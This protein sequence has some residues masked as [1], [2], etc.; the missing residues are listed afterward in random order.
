MKACKKCLLCCLLASAGLLFADDFAIMRS[1]LREQ[2]ML[3]HLPYDS[4]DSAIQTYV[5][6]IATQADTYQNTIEKQPV[7]YL[8]SD[9]NK[10]KGDQT[11]TCKHLHY[12]LQRLHTMAMAWAYP[13]S[14]L[15]HD[16]TLLYHI[17]TSLDFLY[18]YALNEKTTLIGNF[19]EW[20]IGMPQE[21]AAIVSILYE[22]LSSTQIAHYDSS[23][24]HFVR[25]FAKTGN[26]TYANQADIC[27]N[28]LYMGILTD[29]A[30]D[31]ADCLRMVKRAFVDE[32]SPA[33]RKQ[34]QLLFEQMLVEQG[35]YH[36]YNGISKKEGFYS[37]GT[38]IQHIAIPYIGG[39]GASL[40]RFTAEMEL[41]FQGT[42]AY[43]AP[44]YFYEVMPVWIEKAYIP[45]IYK[46]EMMRMFMGRNVNAAHSSHEAAREI[47]LNIYH[48]RSLI[49]D[50]RMRRRIVEI[51]KTWYTENGYYAT[52]Y[53]GMHPLIDKPHID[54][55]VA[56]GSDSVSSDVFHTVLAAG[57]RI[58]HQTEHF[59]LGIA[60]SGNR[61][62]KFEGFSGNNMSGWYTGD[63]MTYVYTPNHREHWLQFFDKCNFYRM[64][65]TTIDVVSRAAEGAN[66]ALFDNPRN[67]QDWVGG[68]SLQGRYGAAG[69][70]LAGAKSDLVAKK[71]W[72][73]FD[74]E[75]YCMG[76][77]ISMT[78]NRNVE[79]IIESRYIQN[80]WRIDGEEGTSKKCYDVAYTNPKYAYINEVGG[81]VF[82]ADMTLTTYIEQNKLYSLYIDH[83]KA[84]RQAEYEYILL[85]QMS[86]Q[87]VAVYAREPAVRKIVNTD[88]V[89]AV[90]HPS[91]DIVGINFYSAGEAASVYSDGGGCVLFRHCHD[92][93][94][95]AVSD[96]TWKRSEQRFV[97]DGL[98]TL[99]D[100]TPSERVSVSHSDMQ[101][102]LTIDCAD[103]MGQGQ[104]IVLH[105]DKRMPLP[106]TESALRRTSVNE[107]T[108]YHKYMKDG[109]LFIRRGEQTYN[110]IGQIVF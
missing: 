40:I 66:I 90:W 43:T 25:Q 23:F 103:R 89:Q 72:F 56:S 27:R 101:T 53:D 88:S 52:V 67:A 26:L 20:R 65:G 110:A 31:I 62:G 71:A 87:A 82:P 50:E 5:A 15:Y 46:G 11:Y 93:L 9:Y 83:G 105:T 107:P 100:A 104:Q 58:I 54:A 38:F 69:M 47:G 16:S 81:Y 8:W 6:S 59:R 44:A 61:I 55:L 22:E 13:T 12:T 78:E 92:T 39:Y 45:A 108:K 35:D 2:V 95:F 84:P 41:C 91:K 29:N 109:Q 96:P 18:D 21:Y 85:P 7:T 32:T 80:G 102:I 33:E 30:E 64:P 10:L 48:S 98:Y 79:T 60:M 73:C 99:V 74:N 24:T 63:G 1:N 70:S 75:I 19:W 51:C 3:G 68:V 94:Y 28:L 76:A 4:T 37:D 77:G 57:D 86:E 106:D 49:R 34:A 97:L 42:Q 14:A 17:K 36:N